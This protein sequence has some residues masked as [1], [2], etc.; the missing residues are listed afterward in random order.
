MT[1]NKDIYKFTASENF[2]YADSSA[3]PGKENLTV[4]NVTFNIWDMN[5]HCQAYAHYN[6]F[7][8]TI[9]CKDRATLMTVLGGL[10]EVG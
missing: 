7:E 1:Y 2:S 6:G 3:F 8:Y 5:G 4:C 9:N 10:E